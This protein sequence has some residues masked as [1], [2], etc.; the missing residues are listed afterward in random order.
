MRERGLI[1][2]HSDATGPPLAGHKGQ[3]RC[4]VSLDEFYR[5]TR[6]RLLAYLYAAGGELAEAQDADQDADAR[7]WRRWSSVGAMWYTVDGA[8]NARR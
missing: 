4:G 8:V 7:A 6:E 2:T 5:D 1:H 3:G